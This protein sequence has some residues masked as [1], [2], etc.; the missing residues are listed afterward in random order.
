[1]PEPISSFSSPSSSFSTD[2][3]L[4][5]GAKVCRTGANGSQP[6]PAA[7]S[8]PPPTPPA[9]AKLL[10]AAPPPTSSLPPISAPP[11]QAENNAQRTSERNGVTPYADAGITGGSRDALFAGAAGLKGRDAASGIE[12]EVLSVS[13]QIGGEHE[14]QAALAR[15]GTSGKY[16]SAGGEVFTAR[17][18]AGAHNDDGSIGFNAGLAATIVGAEGTLTN[19]AHSITA[20]VSAGASAG[21]SVG[22]R[23]LDDNGI[24]EW[25]V[26]VSAGPFTVGACWEGS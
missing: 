8:E 14:L 17:A 9:V 3:T 21:L 11:S 2:P 19:G 15:V 4:D 18:N 13:A 26:K 6:A 12:V 24:N 22:I 20:G 16:G 10:S 7:I 23:D 1:M 25:C 5:E